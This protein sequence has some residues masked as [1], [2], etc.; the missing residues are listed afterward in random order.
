[1]KHHYTVRTVRVKAIF[2]LMV[3]KWIAEDA[4]DSFDAVQELRQ[5]CLN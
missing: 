3:M 5:Y 1:M 4:T 2:I